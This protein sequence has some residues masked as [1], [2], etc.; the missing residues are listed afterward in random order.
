M[1]NI[2]TV[3]Y[4]GMTHLGL[5]SA[6]SA[7]AKG[8]S[9]NI[10][11]IGY[12]QDNADALKKSILPVVEPDLNDLLTENKE[13]ISFTENLE[14]LKKC[15]ILYIASDVPTNDKA[16]SDLS[17]I[18]N[19]VDKVI[20]YLSETTVIV[21]LSQVNPGFTRSLEKKY[22]SLLKGRLF[23]QV[24]TLIF[25]RAVERAMYPERFM[26]GA[27]EKNIALPNS[28]ERFLSIFNCPIFVMSYESAE[29][30]KISINMY[31]VSTVTT[32]NMLA[33]VCD[34]IG[35]EWNDI[36]ETLRLDKRIGSYAYLSPGLGLSGGNLE[37]DLATI[38]NLSSTH[39]NNS[40][41]VK[42]WLDDHEYRA[43]WALRKLHESVLNKKERPTIAVWG[44]SYKINTHSIKN[45]PSL[46]LLKNLHP[47]KV[48]AYDPVVKEIEGYDHVTLCESAMTA[49]QGADV[50]LVMTPWD[51]F[52]SFTI[53]NVAHN[54]KTPTIIDPFEVFDVSNNKSV[55]IQ[56]FVLGKA[57]KISA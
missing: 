3:G 28:L 29:L 39:G 9:H 5:V 48:M 13:N 33:E 52:K 7:A 14:D 47:F 31:L 46:R 49:C 30:A 20:S 41:L 51:E 53:N 22:A 37:R 10:N 11:I 32:T 15:D 42:T 4:A 16:E 50:L 45:S 21:I 6:I 36:A 24:E 54:M 57:N 43:D 1:K 55:N 40:T 8:F 35:A 18:E 26:I 12:Q 23:Y 17:S 34:K 27:V 44:L 38:L 25:G 56:Y 2:L 19:L